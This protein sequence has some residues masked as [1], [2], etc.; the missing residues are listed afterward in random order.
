MAHT[1]DKNQANE[2]WDVLNE[3][4]TPSGYTKE[5]GTLVEGEYHLVV[6][7]WIVQSNGIF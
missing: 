7:S 2:I 6:R 4:S 1:N 3:D 5:R